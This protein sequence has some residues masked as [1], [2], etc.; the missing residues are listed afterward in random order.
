[1]TEFK[2]GDVVMLYPPTDQ[3]ITIKYI[4]ESS[5]LVCLS[6]NWHVPLEDLTLVKAREPELKMPP[7]GAVFRRYP[8][9]YPDEWLRVDDQGKLFALYGNGNT[10]FL[11]RDEMLEWHDIRAAVQAYWEERE[12]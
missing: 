12:R 1:M 7:P 10:A 9:R 5:M 3:H 4:Y 8:G 11:G 6:N 2:V